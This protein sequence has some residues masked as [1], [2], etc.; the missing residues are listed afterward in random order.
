M[1]MALQATPFRGVENGCGR[2]GV[3]LCN[4]LLSWEL[5]IFYFLLKKLLTAEGG[6]YRTC[7]FAASDK[8]VTHRGE[9]VL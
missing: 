4:S 5:N 8:A 6:F 3:V 9:R 1:G 7:L 2:K